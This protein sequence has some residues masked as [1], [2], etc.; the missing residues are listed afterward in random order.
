[1]LLAARGSQSLT[2]LSLDPDTMSPI[3]GCQSALLT[4]QWWPAS[5]LS[6]FPL[7][8]FQIF[9]D[10]SSE[11]VKNLESLGENAMSRIASL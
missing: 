5:V 7:L 2:K 6:S 11:A 1:M 3:L 10:E 9:I 4:S 8:K